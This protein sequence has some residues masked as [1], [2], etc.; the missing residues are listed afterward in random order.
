M[1]SF[2]PEGKASS[3]WLT[4]KDAAE[5]ARR[6]IKTIY[7]W[8]ETGKLPCYRVDNKPML[9]TSDIDAMYESAKDDP[10]STRR[11]S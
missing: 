8:V 3:P 1:N 11:R 10:L 2:K 9:K 4:M 7:Y 5:Y 6:S